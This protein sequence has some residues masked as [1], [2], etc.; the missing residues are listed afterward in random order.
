[1]SNATA[2]RPRLYGRLTCSDTTDARALFDARSFDYQWIDI[3]AD[4]DGLTLVRELNGGF[5]STPVLVL[6]GGRFLTEPAAEDLE[7]VVNG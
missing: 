6:P 2:D 4:A 5:E 3:D 7:A 1:M